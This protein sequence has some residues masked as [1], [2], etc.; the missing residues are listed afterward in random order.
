M[1]GKQTVAS[2]LQQTP[3]EPL[4]LQREKSSV[5]RMIAIY[6]RGVHGTGDEL[7]NDCQ[8]LLDYAHARLDRCVFGAEKPVCAK[9]PIHCYKPDLRGQIQDVMR[10]AGPRMMWHHPLMAVRHLMDKA[11]PV[12]ERPK[13]NAEGRR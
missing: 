9:C 4:H 10:Y 5:A 12:P 3:S 1:R 2:D 7:C 6:C 11:K 8:R 13:K